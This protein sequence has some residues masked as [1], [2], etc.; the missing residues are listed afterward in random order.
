M[1]VQ[2]VNKPTQECLYLVYIQSALCYV[3]Q[4]LVCHWFHRAR[5]KNVINY[6]PV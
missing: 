2:W 1:Y 6:P 5:L 4:D 3:R